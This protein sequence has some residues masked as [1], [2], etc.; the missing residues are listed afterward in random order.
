MACYI[1]HGIGINIE[2]QGRRT[3]SF[4]LA[5]GGVGMLNAIQVL[6]ALIT[7]GQAHVGMVVSSEVNTDRNPDP[8]YPYPGSGAAVLLDLAPRS[9]TGFGPFAFRT[10]EEH[11]EL[12]T[13]HVRLDRKRGRLVMQRQSALEDVY[14]A[15][16]T[17]AAA[18]ILDRQGWRRDEVD[19]VV[20]AQISPSFLARL[21]G[22]IGVP[23]ERV[24]DLTSVLPDTHSTSTFLA[25]HHV[26]TRRPFPPG[27][28]VLLLACGSG[29]TVGAATYTF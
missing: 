22:A 5:N 12:F 7:S 9:G 25:L 8:A 28:R 20:P 24:A 14:L 3:A 29:V 10:F 4:D 23:R 2:F 6:W 19:L 17:A 11:A 21:P 15:G 18:E 27:A 16:T 13:S 26:Q 1:Q